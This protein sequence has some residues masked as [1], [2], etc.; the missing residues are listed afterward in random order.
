[1]SHPLTPTQI[2]AYRSLYGITPANTGMTP[3]DR[4]EARRLQR[5][6]NDGRE[7]K[8]SRNAAIT[9][10]NRMTARLGFNVREATV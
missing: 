2:D 1:M 6:V 9:L 3:V 4:C 5:V 8:N 10:L 7:S